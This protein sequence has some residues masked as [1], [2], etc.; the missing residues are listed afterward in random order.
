ML[1][2]RKA[3]ETKEGKDIRRKRK[4]PQKNMR[5]KNVSEDNN[6]DNV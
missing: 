2:E 1:F 5:K 4:A 6:V 3:S